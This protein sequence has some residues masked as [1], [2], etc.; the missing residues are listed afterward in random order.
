MLLNFD[1]EKKYI[2]KNNVSGLKSVNDFLSTLQQH[3]F[4]N[5]I[6]LKKQKIST[7]KNMR[8]EG[9]SFNSNKYLN[10]LIDY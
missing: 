10:Q 3:T 7:F 4:F 8:S 5:Y 1:N 2:Y 6:R 9:K